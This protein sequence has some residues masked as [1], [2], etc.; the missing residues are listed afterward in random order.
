MRLHALA[1]DR[2]GALRV[3][4]GCASILEQELGV[5]PGPEIEGMRQQLLSDAGTGTSGQ[6]PREP[7]RTGFVGRGDELRRELKAADT[8][9]RPPAPMPREP[10]LNRLRGARRRAKPL[11]ADGLGRICS[12]RVHLQSRSSAVTR[13]LERRV[14]QRRCVI[15][16]KGRASSYVV[17]PAIRERRPYLSRPQHSC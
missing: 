1:G 14:W 17:P 3:Y 11:P 8:E 2:A 9:A 12:P 4:H 7:Q 15:G 6:V 16:P 13:E 5:T 10:Q